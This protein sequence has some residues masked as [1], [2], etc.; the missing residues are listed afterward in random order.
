MGQ[1]YHRL[2]PGGAG[3]GQDNAGEARLPGQGE[4]RGG[5]ERLVELCQPD[6]VGGGN[7]QTGQGLET[8]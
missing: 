4:K 3:R 2:E 8:T 1:A 5:V 7:M 6:A